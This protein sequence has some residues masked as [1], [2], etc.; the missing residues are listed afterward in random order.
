MTTLDTVLI[1]MIM[2]GA[3][4]AALVRPRPTPGVLVLMFQ[5]AIPTI[6]SALLPIAQELG[7]KPVILPDGT[8]HD[9]RVP[10]AEPPHEQTDVKTIFGHADE[11]P[12]KWLFFT[13]EY[14]KMG[15]VLGYVFSGDICERV[16][17]VCTEH[18]AACSLDSK[19]APRGYKIVKF[20]NK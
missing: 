11:S 12:R 7:E 6:G 20:K 15:E 18:G 16:A 8:I 4:R 9:G 14:R 2:N 17:E 1:D 3:D 13:M 5:S 10:D 19:T